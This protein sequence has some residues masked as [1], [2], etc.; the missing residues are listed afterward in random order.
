MLEQPDVIAEFVSALGDSGQDIEHSAV[1]FPRISL[2]RDWIDAI[3]AH[4]RGNT[5]IQFANFF[6]VL[7]EQRHETGLSSGCPLAAEKGQAPLDMIQIF[8]VH[9]KILDP[10]GCPFADG[11]WLRRL[12]MGE[13]QCRQIP[14]LSCKTGQ[15]LNHRDQSGSNQPEAFS[16]QDQIGIV[17]DIA[18]CRTQVDDSPG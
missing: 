14:V 15:T 3:K 16:H 6:L 12:K 11:H 9:Q 4:S 7:V 8:Q 2:P 17:A 10:Q 18:G 5:P 13:T 1:H